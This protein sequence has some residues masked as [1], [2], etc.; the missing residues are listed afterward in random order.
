MPLKWAS[1]ILIASANPAHRVYGQNLVDDRRLS[2]PRQQ[3]IDGRIP[4]RPTTAPFVM[5]ALQEQFDRHVR[6][7]PPSATEFAIE[8]LNG[9]NLLSADHPARS[10]DHRSLFDICRFLE[11]ARGLIDFS[12]ASF[13]DA[14][15][16][17]RRW[18]SRTDILDHLEAIGELGR[19]TFTAS[20]LK[21][22]AASAALKNWHPSWLTPAAD[23][24]PIASAGVEA[25]LAASGRPATDSYFAELRFTP[26]MLQLTPMAVPTWA[27]GCYEFWHPALPGADA[28]C[29]Y[30]LDLRGDDGIARFPLR[31]FIVLDCR[32]LWPQAFEAAD[33]AVYRS[34]QATAEA[35]CGFK[36]TSMATIPGELECRRHRHRRRLAL[37][38]PLAPRW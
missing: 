34:S 21:W 10:E 8:T 13:S 28:L 37:R 9:A 26:P 30:G 4:S 32:S 29:G 11:A 3:R 25:A 24:L 15:V 6:G 27:D 36:R 22:A 16:P 17:A 1:D 2:I 7:A 12:D 18:I 31:E 20:L 14:A 5:A 35:L 23:A 33:K 19:R 38:F